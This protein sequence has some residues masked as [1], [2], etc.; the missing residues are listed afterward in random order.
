[1]AVVVRARALSRVLGLVSFALISCASPA[2]PVEIGGVEA[3]VQGGE[4]EITNW[5]S[6]PVFTFVIG[7]ELAALALWGPCVDAAKCPPIP[8][9]GQRRVAFPA[10]EKEALVYW[11]HAVPARDGSLRPDSIRAGVVKREP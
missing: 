5:T 2:A 10:G 4:I 1:M 6:E 3:V 9:G 7:R 8:A 11:W